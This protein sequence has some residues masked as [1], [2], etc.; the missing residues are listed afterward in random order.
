MFQDYVFRVAVSN[1]LV[2]NHAFRWHVR[3]GHLQQDAISFRASEL[4]NTGDQAQT[5][6]RCQRELVEGKEIVGLDEVERKLES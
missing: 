2:P 5:L 6:H 3:G 1:G 4:Q